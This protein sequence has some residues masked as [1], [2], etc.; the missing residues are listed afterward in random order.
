MSMET[1]SVRGSVFDGIDRTDSAYDSEIYASSSVAADNESV[2]SHSSTMSVSRRNLAHTK[3]VFKYLSPN[4][5]QLVELCNI[6]FQSANGQTP[7]SPMSAQQNQQQ[8]QQEAI[9]SGGDASP[10]SSVPPTPQLP[11]VQQQLPVVQQQQQLP[12]RIRVRRDNNIDRQVLVVMRKDADPVE[13][14]INDLIAFLEFNHNVGDPRH[15]RIEKLLVSSMYENLGFGRRLLRELHRRTRVESIEVWALWHAESFYKGLG[16]I[17]MRAPNGEKVA[18]AWGP[19]LVWSRAMHGSHYGNHHQPGERGS[20]D[21]G[22][23]SSRA[24]VIGNG[25]HGF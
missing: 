20:Y 11:V 6:L 17:D 19:L 7:S 14:R 16:Y 18:A 15:L 13:P 9:T 10:A 4:D 21:G 23:S 22:R 12:A 1:E 24:S 5:H 8:Q 2:V 3:A 25:A